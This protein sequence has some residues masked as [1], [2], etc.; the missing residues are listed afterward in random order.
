MVPGASILSAPNVLP[1]LTVTRMETY[2]KRPRWPDN[3]RRHP[4]DA[5]LNRLL[6]EHLYPL[7]A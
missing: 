4:R 1:K 6:H 5:H 3:S 2:V 7:R